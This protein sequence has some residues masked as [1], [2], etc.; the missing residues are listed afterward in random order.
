MYLC[1]S[2][3]PRSNDI[4]S[5]P[6]WTILDGHGVRQGVDAGFGDS[7]MRL[8]GHCA[9]VD[10]SADEDDAS[11]GAEWRGAH[12]ETV[13]CDPNRQVDNIRDSESTLCFFADSTR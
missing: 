2:D 3:W 8:E 1:G 11:A 4:R 13:R 6:E 7:H 9:V 5:Y 12:Y 10:R